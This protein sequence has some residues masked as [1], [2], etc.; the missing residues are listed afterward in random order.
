MPD[1]DATESDNEFPWDIGVFDA[2]CH[3]TD[4]MGSI[5]DVPKM[6][7][8]ALTIMATRAQDQDLMDQ[9]AQSNGVKDELTSDNDR[10]LIPSFGWHPWF[11]HCLYDDSKAPVADNIT[12]DQKREHYNAA[13]KPSPIDD[14]YL[15]QLPDPKPL[16]HYI[17]ETRSRM[18]QYPTALLGE[19]GLDKSFRLPKAWLPDQLNERDEGL[20][21]G[22]REGR[23]LSKYR[24]EPEHQ[25]AVLLAQIKLAGDMQRACSVH[26]VRATGLL[27]ETL[28]KTWK[29]HE[30]EVLT[31]QERKRRVSVGNAHA[32]DDDPKDRAGSRPKTSGPFPPRICLHSYSGDPRFLRQYFHE[33][34]PLDFF[35]SYSIAV[36]FGPQSADWSA[37]AVK[38]TPDDRILIESDLHIAGVKMDN[39]LELIARKV[40]ELKGWDL[41]RGL[42]QLATN[43]HHFVFGT[44]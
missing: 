30:R 35:A 26:G 42:Q 25:V 23:E 39:A 8:H 16:S 22:G 24:V 38:L 20:T 32:K 1:D 18:E 14:D 31:K 12:Q 15:D 10:K 9:V 37:E 33:S 43:W 41:R 11:S 3:P 17:A 44:R 13:L 19:V 2:H 34:V 36:N 7:A 21:P 40:C 6:K 27:F 4:T 29:G 28:Q 5:A